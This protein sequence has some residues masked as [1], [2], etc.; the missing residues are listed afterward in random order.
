LAKDYGYGHISTG[1]L[2]RA[3][4]ADDQADPADKK[5][6]AIMKAGGIVSDEL[7][8]RVAFAEIQKYLAA[9]TGVVLDGA[10]R[11]VSQAERYQT[12]FTE[13]GVADEVLAIELRMSDEIAFSRQASRLADGSGAGRADDTPEVLRERLKHQGNAS[14]APIAEYYEQMGTLKIVN[15]ENTIDEVCQEIVNVL[16]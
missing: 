3:L 15:G 8:Y 4:D 6:L 16:K 12:F 7:I 13:H 11:S 10:I 14:V 5:E 9:G 1:D 2:L